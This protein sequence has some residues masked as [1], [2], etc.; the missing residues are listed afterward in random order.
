MHIIYTEDYVYCMWIT[1]I[2]MLTL[3]HEPIYKNKQK[4][5]IYREWS[6]L[7]I[8]WAEVQPKMFEVM[9]IL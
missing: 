9:W 5:Q 1:D 8:A 3:L 4:Q 2:D 6:R 7:R